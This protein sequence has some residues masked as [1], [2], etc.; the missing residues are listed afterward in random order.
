MT[1]GEIIAIV[2]AAAQLTNSILPLIENA[3]ATLSSND[4]AA[5]STSLKA[6]QEKNDADWARIQALL[7]S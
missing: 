7:Q 2:T 1:P 3:K 5:I 4:F 6:L